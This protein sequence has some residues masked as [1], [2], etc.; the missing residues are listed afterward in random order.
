[1]KHLETFL[2]PKIGLT[3]SDVDLTTISNTAHPWNPVHHALK[4]LKE[5][6]VALPS[7]TT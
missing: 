6:W 7:G 5:K 3:D 2:P 4:E 1:M